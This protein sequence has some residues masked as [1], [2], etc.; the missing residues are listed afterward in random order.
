MTYTIRIKYKVFLYITN[1]RPTNSVVPPV[2]SEQSAAGD[3]DHSGY[4]E[5]GQCVGSH[6]GHRRIGWEL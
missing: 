1:V 3:G 2:D 4:G 6:V 5:V